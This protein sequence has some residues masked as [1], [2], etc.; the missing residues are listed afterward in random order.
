MRRHQYRIYLEGGG[1]F[2]HR[3]K[4]YAFAFVW[5]GEGVPRNVVNFKAN[6]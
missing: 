1:G 3:F 4:V 6:S 2:A 5:D